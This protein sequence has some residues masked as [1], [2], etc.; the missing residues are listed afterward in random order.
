MMKS[1]LLLISIA[2]AMAACSGGTGSETIDAAAADGDAA[3]DASTSP[4]DQLCEAAGGSC[5]CS[6]GEGRPTEDVE[7]NDCPQPCDDCG[8][9]SLF[10]CVPEPL[11]QTVCP[12]GQTSCDRATEVCV[13]TGPVG[14]SVSY[15]CQPVPIECQDFRSCVCLQETMCAA[16]DTCTLVRDN[17]VYCDNG[18]Q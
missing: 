14:P 8:G 7:H 4:F 9:C 5:D 11:P 10:C 12:D 2:V 1:H 16:T 15:G 6:C 18:T 3:F 13:E 17:T